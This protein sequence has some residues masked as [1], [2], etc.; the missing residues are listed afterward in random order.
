[1]RRSPRRNVRFNLA[2]LQPLNIGDTKVSRIQGGSARFPDSETDGI[3]G[4]K[5]IQLVIGMIGEKGRN[6]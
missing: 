3:N 4:G 2:R 6:N 1:M 5:P